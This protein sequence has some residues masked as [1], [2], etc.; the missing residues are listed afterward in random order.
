MTKP[1]KDDVEAVARAITATYHPLPDAP[2]SKGS[3]PSWTKNIEF[4][5]AAITALISRGY[6][7]EPRG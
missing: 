7:K 3:L 5:E 6:R 1:T 2:H 4:A